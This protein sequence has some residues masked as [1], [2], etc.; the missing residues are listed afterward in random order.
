MR[1]E[2]ARLG[3]EVGYHSYGCFDAIRFP[4]GTKIG[5]YCSFAPTSHVF[6][7]NHGTQFLGL[8]AYFYD[9]RLGIAPDNVGPRHTL[10]ISDD[11]W[12]GHNA[13]ILP[14]TGTI[15]RGAVVA[16]G[17]VVTR[18]VPAYA[19]VAGS[20]ARVVKYRFDEE[21][22]EKIEATQWWLKEPD[23]LKDLM[24]ECPEL[25]FDPASYFNP[26]RKAEAE[27]A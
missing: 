27:T 8:T 7:I 5:R 20:P 10:E 16:A 13:I 6:L 11:V 4:P 23:E 2:F 18:P 24:R 3:I 9:Q 26:D 22:I 1:A 19:I 17:A 15:G 21:T 12:L 14:S 25:V